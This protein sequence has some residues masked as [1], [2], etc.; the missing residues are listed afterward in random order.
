MSIGLMCMLCIVY[1]YFMMLLLLHSMKKSKIEIQM[2][3]NQFRTVQNYRQSF[4]FLTLMDAWKERYSR[5]HK[6]MYQ[7]EEN[8]YT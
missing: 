3:E 7:E 6:I 1:K 8:C 4:S 2:V 5:C